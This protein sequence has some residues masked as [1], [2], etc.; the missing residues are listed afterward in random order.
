MLRWPGGGGIT[1]EQL[2]DI[3]RYAGVLDALHAWILRTACSEAV[4]WR[5]GGVGAS[6]GV[7]LGIDQLVGGTAAD[8][9][10]GALAWSGLPPAALTIGIPISAVTSFPH[11]SRTAIPGLQALGVSVGIAGVTTWPLPDGIR[12]P[13][14]EWVGLDRSLVSLLAELPTP[15]AAVDTVA[16]FVSEPRVRTVAT[17]VETDRELDCVACL[18]VTHALGYRFAPPTAARELPALLIRMGAAG[19]TKIG[20]FRPWSDRGTA[21]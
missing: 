1:P 10:A 18:G 19:V 4:E 11:D 3:A 17:G 21:T 16:A 15:R 13:S 20:P 14:I 6:V 12:P 8:D 9:V 5:A 2:I 7:T